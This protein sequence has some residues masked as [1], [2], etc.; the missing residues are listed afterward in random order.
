MIVR[1]CTRIL[2]NFYA[3]L[4]LFQAGKL[5]DCFIFTIGRGVFLRINSDI[6]A[7]VSY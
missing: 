6:L 7:S 1:G 2:Y 3:L 5:P 4:S